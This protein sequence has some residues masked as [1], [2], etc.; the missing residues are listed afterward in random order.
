MKSASEFW[1]YVLGFEGGCW[2]WT[3]GIDTGGYGNLD[4]HGKTARAHRIAYQLT[5]GDLPKGNGHH[6]S[7]VMHTCDNR[8]CCNPSH[9]AVGTHA[10]N[11]AD[12]AMKNRR[13]MINAGAKNGRA[14]LTAEQVQ[15]IRADKRGKRTIAPEYGI[16]A[17]QVQR[18]RLGQ[19]WK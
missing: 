1:S 11:M 19:H 7:V 18:V 6:G 17:A 2:E 4:W 15:A 16:S 9:L 10:D 12:M 3:G 8:L 13:K 14:K 5:F